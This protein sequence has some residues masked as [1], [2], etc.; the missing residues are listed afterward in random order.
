MAT[1]DRESFAFKPYHQIRSCVLSDTSTPTVGARGRHQLCTTEVVAQNQ[2]IRHSRLRLPPGGR[3]QT[4][5]GSKGVSRKRRNARVGD[6]TLAGQKEKERG[7]G[8]G[9]R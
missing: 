7:R 8:D 2:E 6:K 5:N 3:V 4:T 1:S 9:E